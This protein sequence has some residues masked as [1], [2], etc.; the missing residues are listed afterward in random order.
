M[1]KQY[2]NI[3]IGDIGTQLFWFNQ[4]YKEAEVTSG[5]FDS[6]KSKLYTEYDG[7][8]SLLESDAVFNEATTYYVKPNIFEYAVPVTAGA[9][10]SGS[11]ESFDAPETDLDFIPKVG[12][13]TTVDNIPYTINY[14]GEKY[15]RVEEITSNVEDNIYME[16]LQDGSAMLFKGTSGMPTLTGG[17]IRQINMTIIPSFL[18]LITDINNL[19]QK[20]IDNLDALNDGESSEGIFY[21]KGDKKSYVRIDTDS[22]PKIRQKYQASK[23]KDTQ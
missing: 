23:V 10:F 19:T 7:D 20:D 6:L 11:T 21:I 2:T 1:S 16:V 5:T 8:Y 12:G 3:A 22:I 15:R 4:K 14:T 17:D 18:K 9:D 13:R